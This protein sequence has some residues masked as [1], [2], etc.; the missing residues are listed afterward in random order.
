MSEAFIN[1]LTTE[2]DKRGWSHRELARRVG[3]SQPLVSKTIA[4]EQ[5]V[6]ANLCI[7]VAIALDTPPENLLRLAGILPP[8]H[9]VSPTD[10]PTLQQLVELARTL[11]PDKQQQV[12][13]YVRFIASQK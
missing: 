4:G 10:T 7:A 2:L 5:N 12:L 11:P 3:L 13:E 9:P 1:W 6:S 8:G